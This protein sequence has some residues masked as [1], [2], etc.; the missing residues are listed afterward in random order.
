V[1][2]V[3]H[4][5]GYFPLVALAFLPLLACSGGSEGPSTANVTAGVVPQSP[6]TRVEV[7][8]LESSE[9]RL[10]IRLPGEITGSRD[11][12]LASQAGGFVEGV[13]VKRGDY[14]REGDVIARV[15]ASVYSAQKDQ[16]D[17]QYA[18]AASELQRVEALG[19]LASPAQLQAVRTQVEVARANVRLARVNANRASIRAP[20]SGTVTQIDLEKG[21][22]LNPTAPVA[23]VVQLDPVKVTVSVTDRDV[24]VLHE[25]MDVKISVDAVAGIFDGR[26]SSIDRAADLNTRT[27]LAEITVTNGEGRLLPG[28]IATAA[29]E[30][31]VGEGSVVLPQDWLVTSR[32]GL[33]VF[34]DE[35]GTARWRPVEAGTVVHD[36][37]VV[38]SGLSAGDRVVSVGHRDLADGDPLLISREGVCCQNGR[39]VF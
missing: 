8:R 10:Q 2:L 29:I 4:P 35:D 11:A 3:S 13:Y 27:F 37:V 9:A 31:N 32:D 33:G 20:F 28:M 38:R 22:V 25:G 30:A 24:G 7:V 14:V 34:L 1:N 26:I 21:E 6:G 12:T 19:D 36:Q 15:N 5:R 16:A 18:L 23:R 39:A 17:A